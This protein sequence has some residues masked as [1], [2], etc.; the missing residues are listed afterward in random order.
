MTIFGNI[1]TLMENNGK[2]FGDKTA[3]IW[4]NRY[5]QNESDA[6][7]NTSY[8]ELFED[9]KYLSL[10]F[11]N[12]GFNKSTKVALFGVN[13]Y[14]LTLSLLTVV[15][16]LGIAGPVNH[17]SED[18]VI[19]ACFSAFSPDYVIA[20]RSFDGRIPAGIKRIYTDEIL[21]IMEKE[22]AAH[23]NAAL[24]E[25]DMDFDNDPALALFTLGRT[26]SPRCIAY[27]NKQI[28]EN[29]NAIRKEIVLLNKNK[30]LSVM[31]LASYGELFSGLFLPLSRGAEIIYSKY[32]LCD[33]ENVE[34]SRV[35]ELEPT[36]LC[37][38]PAKINWFYST[39]WDAVVKDIN[40]EN[41]KNFIQMVLKTGSVRTGL[42]QRYQF[43][44]EM[45]FGPKIKFIISNG[46]ILT[47]TAYTGMRAF[48][49][50]VINIF[51]TA[52]CP[53][54][55]IKS[56]FKGKDAEKQYLTEDIEIKSERFKNEPVG[57]LKIRG[58]RVSTRSIGSE[59]TVDE[60]GWLSTDDFVT[61]DENNTIQM[62][63]KTT[64]KLPTN[65]RYV[66]PEHIE[67]FIASEYGIREAYVYPMKTLGS[68]GKEEYIIAARV[69]PENAVLTNRGEEETVELTVNAINAVNARIL[70]YKRIRHIDITFEDLKRCSDCNIK[71]EVLPPDVE[72]TAAEIGEA[73]TVNVI[74][75][76]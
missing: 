59:S 63:G 21:T 5:T 69:R 66:F 9:F 36:V 65:G 58:S 56:P 72:I 52:E 45:P 18:N 32:D 35:V 41:A 46:G 30:F 1:R 54:I 7:I 51:G 61:I 37:L 20:D 64:N 76:K 24:P 39:I 42:K 71:R 73:F 48:G 23:P 74:S 38:T 49:I 14:P 70:P 4:Q 12:M 3:I 28:Y 16:G 13:S 62:F 34:K 75:K 25:T 6:F 15:S 31:P 53:I 60:N 55:A 2:E 8:F 44:G 22:K 10:A 29:A 17:R 40:V 27:T 26:G 33:I 11:W 67:R 43:N 47:S 19:A 68:D 57:I 50:P